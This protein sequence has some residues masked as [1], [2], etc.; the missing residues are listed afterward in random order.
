MISTI[1]QRADYV[2]RKLAVINAAAA[3]DVE[4]VDDPRDVMAGIKQAAREAMDELYWV[5]TADAADTA[6]PTS[7]ERRAAS[8][9]V[10]QR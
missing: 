9:A 2:Y 8:A 7:D 3:C 5:T 4:T 10:G 6:A 1:K